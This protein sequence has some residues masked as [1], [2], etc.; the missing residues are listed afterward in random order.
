M[1]SKNIL[2][3]ALTALPFAGSAF[4]GSPLLPLNEDGSTAI[5]FVADATA[6]YNDNIFYQK[7]K[8]GDVIFTVAPGF[9]LV[10]GGDGNT[11]FNLVF[12]EALTAY[13]DHSQVN[14]QLA[15]VDAKL[16][17]EAGGPAKVSLEGG[18]HQ[19]A[20]P[21]N[22]T[23]QAGDIVTTNQ[24]NAGATG[25]YK[26]TEKSTLV[27]GVR[28]N[29]IRYTNYEYLYN[30]LDTFS[31][32]VS[33]YY[34]ITDKLDAGLTY[35]YTYSGIS[36]NAIQSAL[37]VKAGNQQIHFIGLSSRGQVTDKL[38][39]EANAGVGYARLSGGSAEGTNDTTFNF[40]L[41]ST[42]AVTEKLTMSLTGAREFSVSAVGGQV[43][44]TRGV[45]G[46]NYAISESWS[47]NASIGYMDQA[48]ANGKDRIFTTGAGVAY[49]PNKYWK[50]GANYSYMN[51]DS[52]R[53]GD[54]DN[55]IFSF[56][57]SLKY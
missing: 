36:E 11:K 51:D 27:S 38:K 2:F 45:L 16:D 4:A 10:A 53:I 56:T 3:A 26:A 22:Q 40:S 25:E 1:F 46:A 34:G 54:F 20:Q 19:T 17:Y 6:A 31:V 55:H 48:F 21:T 24:F 29:G 18:F 23:V 43:T 7:D 12:K 13:V 49:A 52:T 41:T 35:Q 42:Y 50:L 30:D 14:N 5:F 44:T 39:L 32:P 8:T 57:A 15:N 47:T 28:Y 33:W 37:G 9:E